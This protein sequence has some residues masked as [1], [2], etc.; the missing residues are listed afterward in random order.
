MTRARLTASGLHAARLCPAKPSRE[1]G[2]ADQ[3]NEYSDRGELL[4]RYFLSSL[5]RELLSADDQQFLFRA[6]EL[7]HRVVAQFM[8]DHKLEG[9]ATTRDK[10][11]FLDGPVPG[12]PDI[13]LVWTQP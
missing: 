13:V 4:H 5:P 7:A 12:T 2:F 11:V 6:D 1:E 3:R 8:E 9:P 10:E